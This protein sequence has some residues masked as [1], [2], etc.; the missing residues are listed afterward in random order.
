MIASLPNR[1]TNKK[2][3]KKVMVPRQSYSLRTSDKLNFLVFNFHLGILT[4]ANCGRITD[5]FFLSGM[6]CFIFSLPLGL[7]RWLRLLIYALSGPFNKRLTS[8]FVRHVVFTWSI[9]NTCIKYIERENNLTIWPCCTYPL[10]T[11]YPTCA[12]IMVSV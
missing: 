7:V 9:H 11:F 2:K 10:F 3:R 5:Y 6:R 8:F 1:L 12:L 4:V